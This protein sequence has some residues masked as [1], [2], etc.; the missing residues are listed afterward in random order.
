MTDILWSLVK[1]PFGPWLWLQ[2]IFFITACSLVS[3]ILWLFFCAKNKYKNIIFDIIR[4]C[5]KM[6]SRFIFQLHCNACQSLCD[7]IRLSRNQSSHM[8]D[9]AAASD[10]LLLSIEK[11]GICVLGSTFQT[12]FNSH[13]ERESKVEFFNFQTRNG[14]RIIGPYVQWQSNRV[15]YCQW[16][17]CSTNF[18]WNKTGQVRSF[19]FSLLLCMSS[20]SSI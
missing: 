18:T 1:N 20:S 7:I 14:H 11:W 8:L 4:V 5:F 17:F 2:S 19:F 13:F 3:Y 15:G 6:E 16:H 10:V 9:G 12:D